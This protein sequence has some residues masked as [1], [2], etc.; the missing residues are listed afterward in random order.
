MKI[1]VISSNLIGDTILS[2][3]AVNHFVKLYPNSK[4][5]FIAG[6]TSGQIYKNFSQ[7]DKI[8]I[9]KKKKFNLH[10][11]DI[12]RCS[13]SDK[14]D[15]IIDFRSSIISYFVPS[16]MNFGPVCLYTFCSTTR[17]YFST[18]AIFLA[19]ILPLRG[20]RSLKCSK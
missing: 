5:T 20:S 8:F 6:P 15:I 16:S 4:F 10:W 3:C 17:H 7:K 18:F 19:K 11:L 9:I 14:W 13:I 12:Y 2:T 1:L